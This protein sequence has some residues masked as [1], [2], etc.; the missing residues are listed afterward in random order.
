ME[1][2]AEEP[3]KGGKKAAAPAKGA[4]KATSALEDI[5]D[6]RPRIIQ[7]VKNF[8]EDATP[9]HIT[10]TVAKWFETNVMKVEI[11]LIN[12]EKPDEE[13]LK[14]TM[15]LD[16]SPLLWETKPE[17]ELKW[18]FDKLQTMELL[19]LNIAVSSDVPVLNAFQRK[20]LNPLMVT[21]VA[22][23]G[24][25]YHSEPKY[26]PVFSYFQFVDG[27][28]FKTL[29]MPQQ[30]ECR[31]NQKHVFL[32]GDLDYVKLKEMLATNIVSVELH[33]NDEYMDDKEDEANAIFSAGKAKFTFRDF[34]RANCLQLKLR[35]DVFPLKRDLVD[36]T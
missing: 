11:F 28:K 18:C 24:V 8:G 31:F 20:K 25:P 19:Y 23:K 1:V 22:C 13:V 36:N 3:V 14:E 34:L 27:R 16:L 30:S 12:R 29:D 9:L 7:Y 21:L 26:K 4:P 35:S 17:G 5:T 10:D 6:N 32:L 15:E 33:D 2:A